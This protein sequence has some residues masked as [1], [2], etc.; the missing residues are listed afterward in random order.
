MAMMAPTMKRGSYI[1][2]AAGVVPAAFV[3]GRHFLG[4]LRENTYGIRLKYL[5][6]EG[7]LFS[8]GLP[9]C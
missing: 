9:L 6:S 3:T 5:Q 8:Y 2:N 1:A 7:R 4:L